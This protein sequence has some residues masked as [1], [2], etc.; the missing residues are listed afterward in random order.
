MRH[1]VRLGLDPGDARIGVARS[2]PSGFLATPVETV[3]RG[4]GDLARLR[5]IID[6][7]NAFEV[8][9]GLPRS[10]SGA[11]G[12]AAVKAREF[13]G[14]LARLVAPMPVR[15]FDERLTT[16]T[17]ESMLRERGKKGAKRRAVVDQAAAVVILQ[18]ALDA[19][20]ARGSAPGEVVTVPPTEGLDQQ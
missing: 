10:L 17:A 8:I 12:P 1:G 9:V 6:E 19:E 16:V 15:L 7:E 2:D 11:E 3:Q 20:R 5:Q 18:H 14:H 4:E 13:A